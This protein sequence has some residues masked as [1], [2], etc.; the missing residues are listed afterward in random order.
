MRRGGSLDVVLKGHSRNMCTI[1]NGTKFTVR[2]ARPYTTHYI[3]N[4][5]GPERSSVS[6]R[7]AI[8]YTPDNTLSSIAGHVDPWHPSNLIVGNLRV[9]YRLQII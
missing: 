4:R 9:A 2:L 6:A 7:A 8:F 3:C 5:L 1:E